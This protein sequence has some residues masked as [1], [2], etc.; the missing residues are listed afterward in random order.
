MVTGM[1]RVPKELV[2]AEPSLTIK[3]VLAS[4]SIPQVQ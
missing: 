3:T 1:K 2:C 4:Q